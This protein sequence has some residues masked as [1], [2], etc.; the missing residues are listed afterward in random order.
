MA[1]PKIVDKPSP[2]AN[3]KVPI[4]FTKRWGKYHPGDV[5]GFDLATAQG[6]VSKGS[7]SFVEGDGV[8][9]EPAKAPPA[10]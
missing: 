10:K 4:K 1:D 8:K 5:A 2:S 3:G 7:A 9:P 6:H